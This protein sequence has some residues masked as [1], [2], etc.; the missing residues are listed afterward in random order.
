MLPIDRLRRAL[1]L[2][3]LAA[4]AAC[5][6]GGGGGGGDGGPNAGTPILD[7]EFQVVSGPTG[8]IAGLNVPVELI[9]NRKVASSSVDGSSIQVVTVE[10]PAG[11]AT[12]GPGLT[13][14]VV[15]S[16]KGKVVT[17]TPIVEFSATEV[18]FGFVEDALY[19]IS[20]SP[21]DSGSFVTSKDGETLAPGSP[22]FFF[23]TGTGAFDFEPGFPMPTAVFVDDPDAVALPDTIEDDD[24]DGS[25]VDEAIALFPG[26]TVIEDGDT[27]AS[28][29]T[30]QILFLFDDAVSPASIF[31][32][33]DGTSDELSV[34]VNTAPAPT[35]APSG[36]S[37]EIG[38]LVQQA[39][40]TIVRWTPLLAA[41]PPGG[42]LF[43]TITA[44]VEDVAGNSKESVTGDSTPSLDLQLFVD[45]A[46]DDTIYQIFEPFDTTDQEDPAT[47]SAEWDSLFPG[48][49]GPVFGGGTGADGPFVVDEKGTAE[50]PGATVVPTGATIDF[51]D[52]VV[53]LPSVIETS[54]GV[55][56]PRIYNLTR[57][58]LPEGWTLAVL[59]DRDE[60]G[61]P[62]DEEFRV[63]S[64]GHPLDGL[65]APLRI[66]C[67][68]EAEVFGTL[69]GRGV[70]SAD[71]VRPV[72]SSDPAYCDY[73]GQ[74]GTGAVSLVAAGDGGDG[75]DV[76]L[77]RENGSIAFG[78]KS[79]TNG[80]G[81]GYE[82][83]DSFACV[84]G[85]NPS[86]LLG[87]TGRSA[88]RTATQLVDPAT[89]LSVLDP[90]SGLAD[91]GLVQLLQ[92]G[93]LRLQPNVGVGAQS[94]GSSGTKNET[95][96]ENH[97][98]F[99]IED[100]EVAAGETTITVA[101]GAGDPTL[102]QISEN[103]SLEPISSGLDCYLVGRLKGRAGTDVTPLAR[104]GDGGE[105]YV[106]VN[107]ATITTTS[108]GGGG[109]GGFLPGLD[110]ESDGP[111]SDPSTSQRGQGLGGMALEDSPGAPGGEGA[112]R[113]TATVVDGERLTLETQ[114][115]G[116]DLA[117]LAS[118]ELVDALL[119]PNA[120]ADG[121]LFE[122][123]DFDGT[124]F[125]V[126]RIQTDELD[127]GL[128]DPG[129]P[130]LS[131]TSIVP[132]AILPPLEFGGAGG[133]GSGVSVTGTVNVSPSDLPSLNP[134]GAGGAGGTSIFLEAARRLV[135]GDA[136]RILTEGGPG[137]T[138]DASTPLSGGG[139]GGGGNAVLRA[140]RTLELFA[141]AL[142]SSQGGTGG[143]TSGSGQGGRGGAGYI[144]FENFDDD[145]DPAQI[146]VVTDPPLDETNVGRFL[147][148]PQGVGQSLFY[149]SMLANP[150]Y[151]A[152][153][154]TYV[155]DVT[156]TDTMTT[157][158]DKVVTWR[159]DDEG[160]TATDDL[161]D[162]PFRIRFNAVPPDSA[163]LL[164]TDAVVTDF[165]SPADL[166]SARADLAHDPVKGVVYAVPG[167]ETSTV[168]RLDEDTLSPLTPDS[169]PLPVIPST[170]TTSLDVLSIAVDA[171]ADEILL[172]ERSTG[173]VHVIDGTTG[174]FKRTITLPITPLGAV[175][176]DPTDELLLVA[177]NAKNQVLG[178]P[179]I[180]TDDLTDFA[181]S[182]F[183][184]QFDLRRDGVR[185]ETEFT[186]LAVDAASDT[187]WAA[188]A[189]TGLLVEF[190]LADGV[191]GTSLTG[192]HGAT[193]LATATSG[194]VLSGLAFT[195]ADLVLTHCVD[196][197]DC[198]VFTIEPA[199][200]PTDGSQTTVASF[201][202]PLPQTAE[203]VMDGD[204]FIRFRIVLDGVKN[205]TDGSIYVLAD[206]PIQFRSVRIE[207]ITLE[208]AN[209]A[210]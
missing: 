49:L 172:L 127:I 139:G 44:G 57:L 166:V 37:A 124:T 201:G 38:F 16:V 168:S 77:L 91:P 64:P 165:F 136:S 105:P 6:G 122:I 54:P 112:I 123:D 130:A 83:T 68:G 36:V 195:G 196:P 18:T 150:E 10:D 22:S 43:L 200:V 92:D 26:A 133:G 170:G 125:T 171:D 80:P 175:A 142:V 193:V 197:T 177:D 96:D 23:R 163:G 202:S 46:P 42:I 24:G 158:E 31:N 69:D 29:P 118:G 209:K 176:Y 33:L 126:R 66:R 8:T 97:P 72:G 48:R 78:L 186:G 152:V 45:G 73:L 189:V 13:A 81:P 188:D 55:F 74:G 1:P 110:G 153:T 90:D 3:V 82:S 62:D 34:S 52:E 65:G 70:A 87:V 11:E 210:F 134:G 56:E 169:L 208:I 4:L 203:S 39:D 106:V 144:R 129:G 84:M 60:D 154:V 14:N 21:V 162:P 61:L 113:G 205:A 76:L 182:S 199:T 104:G 47:S 131:P 100:V 141:G 183:S 164:D 185:L 120:G 53:R 191:E 149:S 9:F 135:L 143:G 114:T 67:S 103:L 204:Q 206:G 12:A 148:D 30:Q 181:P 63:D 167:E 180:E 138:V 59:T 187:L 79:P 32:A 94:V 86:R 115:E 109:G 5:G 41:Y 157:E 156:N 160:I 128:T 95:I 71:I 99:V 174:A 7:E 137:A 101:S 147:G 194:V 98:T 19:E 35:F 121:W 107:D 25:P 178:F 17:I 40:L 117:T 161:L 145:L 198:R 192:T 155:A 58:V 159:F 132:F 27:I 15:F 89:N 75:G 207:A 179:T 184:L 102:D 28:S 85:S 190:D 2:L 88:S 140:G 20:F 51:D 151:D 119:I 93:E 111:P 108:G 50:E 116:T 146:S 173:L